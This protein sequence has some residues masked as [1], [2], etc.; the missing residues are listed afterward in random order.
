MVKTLWTVKAGPSSSDHRKRIILTAK[1]K[2]LILINLQALSVKKF[3][4]G[5]QPPILFLFVLI[6][7][8]L[9]NMGHSNSDRLY[10]F[11]QK[12]R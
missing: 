1:V 8:A 3:F 10:Y 2:K 6:I 12:S 4:E 9:N 5:N 11:T 7:T